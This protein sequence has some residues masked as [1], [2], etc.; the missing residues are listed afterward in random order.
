MDAGTSARERQPFRLGAWHVDPDLCELSNGTLRRHVEPRTMAVLVHLAARHGV[1][2]SR[3][4]LL[5]AVWKTR[6]VV[7]EA[8]TRCISQLRQ[9]LDDDPRNP[10]FLQTIPKLGY[11]LLIAPEPIPPVQ[12]AL[13]VTA[14][15][16]ARPMGLLRTPIGRALF[17]TIGVGVLAGLWWATSHMLDA[18]TPAESRV[19]G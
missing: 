9:S 16:A 10:Q 1:T 4:E 19:Q 11:R 17:M 13:P 12:A 14:M 5:D 8:L 2:V 3:E 18:S 7:E 6:F 15:L